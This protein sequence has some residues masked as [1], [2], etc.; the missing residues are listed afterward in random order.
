MDILKIEKNGQLVLALSGNLDL[1]SYRELNDTLSDINPTSQVTID[2]TGIG[3]VNSSG[4]GTMLRF[5]NGVERAG[6]LCEFRNVP[7]HVLKVFRLLGLEENFG[8]PAESP[9]A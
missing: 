1:E 3:F 2:L 7:P 6:G 5:F 4:V 9:R 8:I